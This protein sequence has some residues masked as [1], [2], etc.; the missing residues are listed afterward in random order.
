MDTLYEYGY[1]DYI[2]ENVEMKTLIFDEGYVFTIILYTFSDVDAY[3]ENVQS[4]LSD[5][6]WTSDVWNNKLS[7]I[8]V[9]YPNVAQ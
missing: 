8:L 6:G 9:Y 2:P 3:P 1:I 7:L 5:K 4:I